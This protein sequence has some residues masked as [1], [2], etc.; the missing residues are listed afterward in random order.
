MGG[1]HSAGHMI[2]QKLQ[3]TK[4]LLLPSKFAIM[5]YQNGKVFQPV[6]TGFTTSAPSGMM[7]PDK[8]DEYP[9]ALQVWAYGYRILSAWQPTLAWRC[10]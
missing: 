9:A 5:V 7:M 2:L 10:R 1:K 4:A 3:A 6:H 8:K